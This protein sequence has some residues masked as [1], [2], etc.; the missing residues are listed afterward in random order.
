MTFTGNVDNPRE[1]ARYLLKLVKWNKE[2]KYDKIKAYVDG[3]H[4]KPFMPANASDE[5]RELA[6]RSI[7]NYIPMVVATATQ[8]LYVDS[9]RTADRAGALGDGNPLWELFQSS[10]CD[11]LQNSLYRGALMYGQAFGTVDPID[12]KVSVVSPMTA[13]GLFDDPLD[14]RPSAWLRIVRRPSRDGKNRGQ[15]VLWLG[16]K[17]YDLAYRDEHKATIVIEDEVSFPRLDGTPVVR[18][19][20]RLG[21]DGEVSGFVEDL[22]TVQD[23]MNQTIFD[24]MC[25]QAE[26]A[27]AARWATG[28]EPP[29][30]SEV[31]VDERTGERRDRVQV[32]ENGQPI[33]ISV[34][35]GPGDIMWS[36]NED[37]RFGTFQATQLD[38]YHNSIELAVK[39]FSTVAQLP[40]HFILGQIANLSAEALMAAT[41]THKLKLA[42]VKNNYGESWEQLLRIGVGVLGN[43]RLADDAKVECVWRETNERSL[44]ATADGLFKLSQGL[45]VPQRA[46]W[47]MIPGMTQTMYD[48]F[49][50]MAEAERGDDVLRELTQALGGSDGLAG[51]A[52][53]TESGAATDAG[54]GRGSQSPG[55]T[56]SRGRPSFRDGG[57]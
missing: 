15:A 2:H 29:V 21:I 51:A 42:E 53:P 31:V 33:P 19:A 17:R 25:V 49:V 43:Q 4:R 26:G 28:M 10:N 34:K 32:D 54:S 20:T 11:G 45:G 8:S 24:L 3:R 1:V 39:Q 22:F 55:S 56:G 30:K 23:R 47:Q 9:F 7:N 13:E 18:F 52:G 50:A 5:L 6:T 35:V 16:N 41:E 46:L 40:P 27:H 14:V 57:I 37:T 44:S 48:H 12:G 36:G 38:G